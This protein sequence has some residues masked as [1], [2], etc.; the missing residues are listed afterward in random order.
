MYQRRVE[1]G[2]RVDDEVKESKNGE[3]GEGSDDM[4][5]EYGRS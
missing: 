3:K 1:E 4:W 5:R 2:K